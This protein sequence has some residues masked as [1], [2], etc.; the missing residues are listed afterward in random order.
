MNNNGNTTKALNEFEAAEFLGMS[1]GTLRHWRH[2]RKGPRYLKYQG[3]QSVRYL[4][5]YLAEFMASSVV[6]PGIDKE[7]S[8][9]KK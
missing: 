7:E 4:E 9:A 1:V 5:Q 2:V 3:S 8:K 6:N